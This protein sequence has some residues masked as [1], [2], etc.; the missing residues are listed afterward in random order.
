MIESQ[1]E[2]VRQPQRKRGVIRFEHLLDATEI[3]Q[4]LSS[5]KKI[6]LVKLGFYMILF[7]I[8]LYR[9]VLVRAARRRALRAT[10]LPLT[11]HARTHAPPLPQ[12][13]VKGAFRKRN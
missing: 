12:S 1:G 6:N 8:F 11:L 3:F 2:R 13:L 5:K 7:F 9:F 10:S 4:Q